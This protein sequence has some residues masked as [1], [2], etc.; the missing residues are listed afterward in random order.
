MAVGGLPKLPNMVFEQVA[1]LLRWQESPT[2]T[3]MLI[4]LVVL[5]RSAEGC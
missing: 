5:V 3:I 1:A 4:I 2:R